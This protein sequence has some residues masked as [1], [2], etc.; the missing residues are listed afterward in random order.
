MRNVLGKK[1]LTLC[2]SR[3]LAALPWQHCWVSNSIVELC[4]ITNKTKE[5]NHVFPLYIY[6]YDDKN[7][8]GELLPSNNTRHANIDSDL[9]KSLSDGIGLSYQPD[10]RGDLSKTFGP[11]DIFYYTYAIFHSP[12]YRSR[13]AEQLKIDFPRLPITSDRNLFKQLVALGNELVNLHLLGENPFDSSKTVLDDS[14]KWNIKIGGTAPANL[15]EWKVTDVYY[16]AKEQRV[17]VNTGQY[18]EGV[19]KEVWE[20]MI[21]G[22]QVCE[23]WLKDRKKADRILSTDDLKHYMKIV[24]TLRETIRLMGEIDKAILEWPMK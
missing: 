17:Y 8:Q 7:D 11:E 19:E 24:V 5:G 12:T 23:K 18:F 20:F 21:G 4:Y 10:G 15:E 13:Y 3:Q 2:T 14:S 16:D 9:V 1:N 22:Y 6:D